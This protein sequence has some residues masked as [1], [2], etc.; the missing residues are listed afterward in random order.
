[1]IDPLYRSRTGFLSLPACLLAIALT[2]FASAASA[3]ELP[4]DDGTYR[5]LNPALGIS[6][7]FGRWNKPIRLVYDPD[8]APPAYSDSN[9]VLALLREAYSYWMQVSDVRFE[10]VGID[11]RAPDDRRLPPYQR[12]GLVRVSWENLGGSAG[13]AGPTGAF[14]SSDLGYFPY[15]DGSVELNRVPGVIASDFDLVGVLV[16]E[17]GHL[18]G[19]GHSDVPDSIMYANP[20]N[21]LRYPRADDIRAVQ[22][23]YGPP[24]QPFDPDVPVAAWLYNPPPH[25][26]AA[27]TQFLFKPNANRDSRNGAYFRIGNSVVTSLASVTDDDDFLWFV[28]A[29]GGGSSAIG[30]NAKFIVVDPTGYIYDERSWELACS[31]RSSCIRAITVGEVGSL[32]TLPGT[33]SVFVV[34]TATNRTLG[35]ASIAVAGAPHI[36]RAPA[37]TITAVPGNSPAQARFTLTASDPE[38]HAIDVVWHPPGLRGANTEVRQRIASGG[39][40]SLDVDFSLAG[41]HTFFVELRDTGPRYG[42]GPNASDAGEGFQT[43]LRVTVSLPTATMQ[44]ASTQPASVPVPNP[45]VSKQVLA[46]VATIRNPMLVTNANGTNAVSTAPASF[47]YGASSSGGATTSTNFRSGDRVIV[48]GGVQP[49]ATDIGQPADV[50]IVVRTIM[51]G[52]E[53]WRYR[54]AAGV[55]VSWPSVALALLQPAYTVTSL[56]PNEAFEI[57]NGSLVATEHR[58]YI[59]YRT[60]GSNTLLYTGE[61]LRLNVSN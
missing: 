45:A 10:I 53:T 9:K 31:A 26:S 14:F 24:A 40:V 29:I 54:N 7:D 37:A 27:D 16:H 52:E 18:L 32:K 20:Y 34:D 57:H 44:V 28:G 17:L 35:S 60:R 47:T 13:Q 6:D 5:N 33:W 11:A 8:N 1:M 49:L 38:G 39:S 46:A 48:A 3:V 51:N 23:L 21:H 55:F 19:L 61:A 12:D 58:V 50:F 36:N 56:Q 42:D 30:I 59:G 15:D 43:L 41:T 25:A 2:L 4:P 22:V